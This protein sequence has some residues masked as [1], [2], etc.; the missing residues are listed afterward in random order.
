LLVIDFAVPS[1]PLVYTYL[2]SRKKTIFNPRWP[3]AYTVKEYRDGAFKY[4]V[5]TSVQIDPSSDYTSAH[6][7][8]RRRRRWSK[9][10]LKDQSHLLLYV[11]VYYF[12]PSAEGSD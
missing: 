8:A 3:S 9:P 11:Q 4:K 6:A 1:V 7:A 2:I 5:V 10:G 12:D